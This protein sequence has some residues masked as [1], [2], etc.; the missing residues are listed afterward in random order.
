MKHLKCRPMSLNRAGCQRVRILSGG[1]VMVGI[2]KTFE[3][4]HVLNGFIN[5]SYNLSPEVNA[6]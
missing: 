1:E 4:V 2:G 6:V 3:C 5:R